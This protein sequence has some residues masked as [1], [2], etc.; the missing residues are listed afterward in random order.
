MTLTARKIA[1]LV[2]GVL[3]GSGDVEIH[4]F[5]KIEEAGSGTI[6]FLANPKY[7]HHIY[8]TGAD[9]VLVRNDFI[10]ERPVKATLIRVEDP[11]VT[12]SELMTMVAKA[13]QAHPEGLESPVSIAEGVLMPE[14]AY[15]GAFTYIA[16]DVKLGKGVKIYPQC[17]VGE[18]SVI[19]E[20]TIMYPGVKIY[21]GSRI[22]RRC[23]LHSGV[24]VGSDGFGFAP[25]P[26][27]EYEKI[28]Q[29][30]HVEIGDDVEIGS[31]TVVD[32]ATM[33]AT[34]IG[35]GVKLDNLIQVAHNVSI[36]NNTVIAAQ[37]G[38]AGSTQIG[39]MC[40]IGGQ[41]GFAGHLTIGDRSVIGAQSGIPNNVAS[42]SRLMGYP[43]VPAGEF[44]RNNVYI[45]KLAS[46]YR[47]VDKLE[48]KD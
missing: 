37:T 1:D 20:G 32:R 13:S 17:Y 29:I 47:R 48:D 22:G 8:T 45:K 39:S 23:I 40:M 11:Y 7:T 25:T 15:V 42:G 30:G 41:V 5:A 35:D 43:A 21:R 26:S 9:A 33:G 4:S 28:P 2:H 18:G 16:K 6:T 34:K 27:G 31:N 19:G 14:G 36:G 44:A 46:L 12:L 3:E 24:V 38:I 10:P